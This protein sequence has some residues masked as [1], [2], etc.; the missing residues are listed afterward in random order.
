MRKV[1]EVWVMMLMRGQGSNLGGRSGAKMQACLVCVILL[2]M[3]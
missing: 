2:C 1:V 3:L